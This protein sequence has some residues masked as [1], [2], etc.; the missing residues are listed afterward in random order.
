MFQQDY[1]KSLD[2]TAKKISKTEVQVEYKVK[3][4]GRDTDHFVRFEPSR[5]VVDSS[6]KNFDFVGILCAHALKILDKKNIKRIPEQYISKRWTK[7]AKDGDIRSSIQVSG[8]SKELIGKRYFDLN[9]NFREI[10]TLAAQDVTMYGHTCEVF[11]KLLKDLQLMKRSSHGE[12]NNDVSDSNH[13]QDNLIVAGVKTKPTVG[14][15]K[16]RLKGPLERRKNQKAQPKSKTD[17]KTTNV[18]QQVESGTQ[19]EVQKN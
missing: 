16:G 8:S 2:C 13:E 3:Y 6:C 14:R 15:P 18:S 4:V 17:N 9:Y 12:T 7:D 10:A 1:I 19:I 11:S 5:Q